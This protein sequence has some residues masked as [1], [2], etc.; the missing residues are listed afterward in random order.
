MIVDSDVD[1]DSG[2]LMTLIVRDHLGQ[3]SQPR[4]QGPFATMLCR[5]TA[6]C[7]ERMKVI[8]P[9]TVLIGH[10]EGTY[11][12]AQRLETRS[13]NIARFSVRTFAVI[14]VL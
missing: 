9:R 11:S 8:T 14:L 10:R 6:P 5:P 13:S 12:N 2:D 4:Y 3:H 1:L 7:T